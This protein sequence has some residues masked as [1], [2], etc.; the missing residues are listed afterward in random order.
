MFIAIYISA[1]AAIRVVTQHFFRHGRGGRGGF[2]RSYFAFLFCHFLGSFLKTIAALSY[3]CFIFRTKSNW[4]LDVTLL[5]KGYSIGLDRQIHHQIMVSW[6][7]VVYALLS[8]PGKC[9]YIDYHLSQYLY[10]IS[11]I[12]YW[13]DPVPFPAVFWMENGDHAYRLPQVWLKDRFYRKWLFLHCKWLLQG[14]YQFESDDRDQFV[15]SFGES[16]LFE[17][18]PVIEFDT[19]IFCFA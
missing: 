16:W 3:P 5:E 8:L 6:C 7:R 15:A 4:S 11:R 10:W 2:G 9:F 14:Y 13:I 17:G 1:I 18:S 19:C 12:T